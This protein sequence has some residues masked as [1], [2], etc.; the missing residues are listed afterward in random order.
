MSERFLQDQITC[1]IAIVP[2]DQGV[3]KAVMPPVFS[4]QGALAEM[5]QPQNAPVPTSVTIT[6]N[7]RRRLSEGARDFFRGVLRP[8]VKHV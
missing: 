4:H 2:P 3:T 6:S 7:E 5:S 1:A 8:T